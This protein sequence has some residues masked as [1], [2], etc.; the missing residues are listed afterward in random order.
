MNLEFAIQLTIAGVLY[1][2]NRYTCTDIDLENLDLD[3]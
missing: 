1:A 3:G 2:L